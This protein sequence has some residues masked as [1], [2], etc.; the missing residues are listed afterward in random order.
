M[1]SFLVSKIFKEPNNLIP[2]FLN[3]VDKSKIG[4]IFDVCHMLKLIRN[5]WARSGIFIDKDGHQI[6]WSYIEK[7]CSLQEDA[8]LYLGNKLRKKH[9]EWKL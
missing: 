9:M 6:K 8:S 5:N 1:L 4:V 3:P 7:L 2:Y